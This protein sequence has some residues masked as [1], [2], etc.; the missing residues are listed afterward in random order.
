M[1]ITQSQHNQI[2]AAIA[3]E[4]LS[5]AGFARKYNLDVLKFF[6]WLNGTGYTRSKHGEQFRFA[7]KQHLGIELT[8]G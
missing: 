4:G 5:I 8:E 1:R 2:K 3:M 7:V 6:Q